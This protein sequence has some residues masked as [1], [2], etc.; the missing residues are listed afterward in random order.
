M[1][2]TLLLIVAMLATNAIMTAQA[3]TKPDCKAKIMATDGGSQQSLQTHH[4]TLKKNGIVVTDG[5]SSAIRAENLE[6]GDS[7]TATIRR[8]TK[9]ENGEYTRVE[10]T[11][12]RTFT[13]TPSAKIFVNMGE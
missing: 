5:F 7:Y 11:R 1:K 3:D 4:I 6:C 2:T 8:M 13:A 10:R 12:T 9:D